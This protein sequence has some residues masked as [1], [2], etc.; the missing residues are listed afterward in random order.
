MKRWLKQRGYTVSL[1]FEDEPELP[2]VLPGEPGYFNG[3]FPFRRLALHFAASNARAM[4]L[5]TTVV[6]SNRTG[7]V[8]AAF[9]AGRKPWWRR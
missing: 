5:S 2:E 8:I 1:R 7:K 9:Q 6:R 4:R 3:W